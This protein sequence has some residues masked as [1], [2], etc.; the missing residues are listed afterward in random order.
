[1]TEHRAVSVRLPFWLTDRP[2][3]YW[4]PKP[5]K[6]NFQRPRR[7]DPGA[8][9]SLASTGPFDASGCWWLLGKKVARAGG[10]D[11]IDTEALARDG[12]GNRG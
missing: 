10:V 3:H 6:E 7:I 11:L 8:L 9:L 4:L 12:R 2:I 1:M 5:R